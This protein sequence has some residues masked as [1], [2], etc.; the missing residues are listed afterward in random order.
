MASLAVLLKQKGHE[1]WGTDQNVYPPM[2]D[3]LAEHSIPVWEGYQPEHLQKDFDIAVIGNALSRG[4]PEVEAILNNRLPFASLTDIIRREF[5]QPLRSIVVT[6]THGKTTTTALTSWVLETAGLSPTFLVGGIS[7]NFH[8]SAKLG[9]GDYFVVEGDEYDSA[10]FDKRPKFL[11]YFPYYLII[12]N[13][14]F[15]HSDIYRDIDQIK[16]GFRKLIRCIPE[17]GLIL[18]N[19]DDP[20]VKEVLTP[21]YS[22]LQTFGKSPACNWRFETSRI[23]F[24]GT[25]F[26]VTRNREQLGEFQIPLY[27]E[28]Q[29]YNS[30]AV[31]ALALNLGIPQEKIRQGL[32]TFQNVKRRLEFWGKLNGADFYDDFAHHPTAVRETLRALKMKHP[33]KKITAVFEP[34][35]NTTVRNI[36]QEELAASLSLADVVIL[37]PLHRAARIPEQQRLSLD[38]LA[39][40][41]KAKETGVVLL[42]TYAAVHK[43][44]RPLANSESVVVLMT[45]GN[46]GGEYEILQGSV[47][48]SREK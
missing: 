3:F 37:T 23:D 39:S 29:L 43:T 48:Q 40:D 15:D 12:N 18:A 19:G 20:V 6:G 25:H 35:T 7:L 42:K 22:D 17:K 38:K 9:T 31:I 13:I 5:A 11:N 1:I 16:D 45:N 26:T 27:G 8:T 28:F 14:E 34:R 4:N 36:F 30:L 33:G 46:L 10:F 44:L 41:L 47:K 32:R 2:S 24:S 21:V